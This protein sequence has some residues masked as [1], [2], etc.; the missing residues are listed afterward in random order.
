[1][2]ALPVLASAAEPTTAPA[3]ATSSAV[4]D[5]MELTDLIDK[6]AKRTGK[7]FIVDPRVRATVA[8]AGIDFEKVDYGK[9]LAILHGPSVQRLRSQRR[10]ASG[11]RRECPPTADSGDHRNPRK[12][13]DDEYVTV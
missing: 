6:V 1:M 13:L 12:A 7:Q 10:R 8:K 9:L 5:G 11:A 3:A 2:V 4:G